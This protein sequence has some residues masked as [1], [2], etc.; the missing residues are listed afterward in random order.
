MLDQSVAGDEF[1]LIN[2]VS[3][4][5]EVCDRSARFSKNNAAGGHIPGAEFHFPES[6]KSTGCD[7]TKV[8]SRTS[9]APHPSCLER[10]SAEMV[11][12]VVRGIANVVRE[13]GDEQRMIELI[14]R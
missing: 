10:E 13:A 11:Q 4:S 8:K 7:V 1:R 2:R 6:V 3:L 14:S 12:I 5:A 9:R